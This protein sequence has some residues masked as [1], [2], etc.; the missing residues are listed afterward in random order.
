MYV[1]NTGS[2]ITSSGGAVLV[3]GTGGGAG[4]SVC[5]FWRLCRHAGT[6]TS[7]GTEAGATVTVRGFGG[8]TTGTGGDNYGVYV[9]GTNSQITSSGGAVLVE[10]TG[11]GANSSSFNY[12]VNLFSAGTITS[13]GHGSR[14]R[15]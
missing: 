6:I 3:E 8:N 14:R 12:G 5:Q 11:G 10:G 1:L 13:C 15:R 4:S 9:N 2:Q 7:A